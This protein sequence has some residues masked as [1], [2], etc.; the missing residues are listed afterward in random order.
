[1][2]NF[3]DKSRNFGRYRFLVRRIEL[4][5]LLLLLIRLLIVARNCKTWAGNDHAAV[6]DAVSS[7]GTHLDVGSIGVLDRC[8]ED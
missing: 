5:R 8:A 1:M 3:L 6:E 4:L 7:E 2:L